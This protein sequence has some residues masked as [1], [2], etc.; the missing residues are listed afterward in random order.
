MG[1]LRV[2]T[3]LRVDRDRDTPVE[4]CDT[5]TQAIAALRES[6]CQ[7][8]PSSAIAADPF[9]EIQNQLEELR[10]HVVRLRAEP[11]G[12]TAVAMQLVPGSVILAMS[13]VRAANADFDFE[14]DR[15]S[16]GLVE[17]YDWDGD[18]HVVY[19]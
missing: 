10:L 15:G 19:I 9:V 4:I 2:L 13:D 17:G 14:V 8:C 3:D 18:L 1:L 7:T 5:G 16:Y 11:L 12:D 6:D